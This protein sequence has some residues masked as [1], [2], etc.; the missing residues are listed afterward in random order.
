MLRFASKIVGTLLLVTLALV[1][2]RSPVHGQELLMSSG[3]ENHLFDF[4]QV[5]P[6]TD[7]YDYCLE[8]N[9]C[10]RDESFGR[11]W[12]CMAWCENEVAPLDPGSSG[13][14]SGNS[15]AC[16][17]TWATLASQ[18][19]DPPLAQCKNAHASGGDTCGS[20][21]ENYCSLALATCSASNPAYVDS[22]NGPNPGGPADLFAD[23]ASCLDAC[24]GNGAE[25]PGYPTEVLDG[26]S[27]TEQQFGYGDTVQCRL[28]HLQ[29]ALI[30]PSATYLHCTHASV[31]ST[32][33]TCS[34]AAVPNSVNYCEFAIEYCNGENELFADKASCR[35]AADPL[36]SG[37]F[38]HFTESTG[39]H[40]GC[41]NYWILTTPSNPEHCASAKV[42]SAPCVD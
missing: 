8:M 4:D 34:D 42:N 37:G 25:L 9:T 10:C 29:A 28:H 6:T 23:M 24:D 3:F 35:A 27:I 32:P 31:N 18:A 19:Q 13:V 26:I 16:R 22:Y 33:G 5:V 17:S 36:P 11:G 1:T 7:C 39:R 20:Y 41:L 40:L 2:V 21:C 15:L 30:E 14:S 38:V 12:Q